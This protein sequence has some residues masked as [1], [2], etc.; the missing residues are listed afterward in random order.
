M[1]HEVSKNDIVLVYFGSKIDIH[2][3]LLNE[4]TKLENIIYGIFCLFVYPK[5]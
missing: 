2:R 1:R 4:Y 3:I 5:Y